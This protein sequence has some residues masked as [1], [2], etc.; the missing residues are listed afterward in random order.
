MKT[1][2]LI[3]LFV[4]VPWIF[5]VHMQARWIL[6][7]LMLMAPVAQSSVVM[8]QP[9]P[10]QTGG[11]LAGQAPVDILK[12]LPPPPAHNSPQDIADRSVY[13]ASALGIGGTGWKAAQAQATTTSPA[14]METLSCALGVKV[15]KETTPVTM[16]VLIRVLTDFGPPMSQ[17]KTYY[18][19]AR[20]FTTDA[21]QACDPMV[22]AGQGDKLGFAYP[23][24]HSGL[25]WLWALILG[26]AAPARAEP[27]RAWGQGVGDH[28]M[29]CRVHWS[30]D[31]AAGRILAVSVY[32][33]VS[34]TPAYQADIKKVS[35]ELA[36]AP[37][38]TCP[39]G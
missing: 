22:A 17:A 4:P 27:I 37:A 12:L 29:D 35:A 36:K 15:S 11:Y 23:S 10:V 18:K 24:G 9:V 39:A 21:G 6:P 25:G 1:L 14:F 33:R 3:G 32:D 8:A 13:A 20:P 26:D 34:M 5:E 38:I 19:R 2:T 30:S 28:R 7:L 31:V 16:D